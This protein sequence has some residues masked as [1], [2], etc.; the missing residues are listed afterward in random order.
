LSSSG[1]LV[2]NNRVINNGSQ[3]SLPG[4]GFSGGGIF[5]TAGNNTR[6][7][8][9]DNEVSGGY[10]GISLNSS[11]DSANVV[12][13]NRVHGTQRAGISVWG[14]QNTIENNDAAG[15]GLANMTPSCRLDM[16]DFDVIDNTWTNNVGTL[17]TS[18]R[19]GPQDVC[20]GP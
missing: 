19:S 12:R 7:Q 20:P 14:Q 15:N 4:S 2:R 13:N 1:N 8:I 5:T 18:V 9:L 16:M 3:Q 6:N 11:P 17:G 10:W